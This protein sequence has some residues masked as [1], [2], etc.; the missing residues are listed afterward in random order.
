MW[1]GDPHLG[2]VGGRCGEYTQ[3]GKGYVHPE[4]SLGTDGPFG[5]AI[6]VLSPGDRSVRGMDELRKRYES[7][8]TGSYDCVDRVVWCNAYFSMGHNPG[9]FRVWWRELHGIAAQAPRSTGE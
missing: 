3:R 8:L 5:A 4:T 9:G 1:P 7:L 2:R 6:G